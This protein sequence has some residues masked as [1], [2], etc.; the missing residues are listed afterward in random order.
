MSTYHLKGP[1]WQKLYQ[2]LALNSIFSS[3]ENP[4]NRLRGRASELP[5]DTPR[6]GVS[7]LPLSELPLCDQPSAAERVQS[8][9]L[10]NDAY[11]IWYFADATGLDLL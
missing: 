9:G 10:S 5:E 4:L 3:S 2:P 6:V 7:E 8:A 1:D 11:S